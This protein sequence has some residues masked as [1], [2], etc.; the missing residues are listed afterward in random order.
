MRGRLVLFLLRYAENSLNNNSAILKSM[1]KRD[2]T[3]K[4]GDGTK[5]EQMGTVPKNLMPGVRIS[6]TKNP[7]GSRTFCFRFERAALKEKIHAL[8]K[9][10]GLSVEDYLRGLLKEAAKT[11]LAPATVTGYKMGL[12]IMQIPKKE[13]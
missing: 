10:S 3:S 9:S 11:H 5:A 1:K 7:D 12:S 2:Y 6:I 13:D 4:P 8:A